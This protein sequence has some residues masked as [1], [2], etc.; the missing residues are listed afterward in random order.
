[1]PETVPDLPEN[2][3]HFVESG[4]AT[5]A[6]G[7][8]YANVANV[9]K[10]LRGHPLAPALTYDK[11]TQR[12]RW[13]PRSADAPVA[14]WNDEAALRLLEL[15]QTV[16]KM[17]RLSLDTVISAVALVA[18][19][20]EVNELQQYLQGLAWDKVARLDSLGYLGFGAEDTDYAL[21][22]GANFMIGAMARAMSP[23][24]Q[25]DHVLVLVGPQGAGKSS[26][27]AILGGPWYG[28]VHADLTSKDFYIGLAT[29]WIAEL[30][31]LQA[32]ANPR[33]AEGYK[34]VIT[35]R[36]DRVRLPYGRS[37]VELPRQAVFA[38]STN[39]R[40]F[41]RDATGN[42]RFWPLTC[43][44]IDLDWIA[45]HRD[46]LWAEAF[47]R[48][49]GGEAF[50]QVPADEQR[51]AEAEHLEQDVWHEPIADYLLGKPEVRMDE[52]LRDGLKLELGRQDVAAQRRAA[53]TLALLGWGRGWAGRGRRYRVWRPVHASDA[54]K[55]GDACA[56][57]D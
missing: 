10:I 22:V 52:L 43:G 33:N 47:A 56:P 44:R 21:R 53:R 17:H 16:C 20:S 32:I 48:W 7:E 27:L 6:R 3:E 18:H 13:R 8:P 46:Q 28:T 19:E 36:H 9:A 49:R 39:E 25:L 55:P 35:T 26:A 24:C 40:A 45:E 4:L 14:D 23:G 42:R 31:E 5:N 41:L 2:R 30:A 12:I 57:S 54:C 34:A 38:G 1:V 50:W 11:S 51:A 15:L 29:L 37:V